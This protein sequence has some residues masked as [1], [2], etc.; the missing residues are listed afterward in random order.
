MQ[1]SE[2]KNEEELELLIENYMD[3]KIVPVDFKDDA[4]HTAYATILQE[5][6]ILN[7]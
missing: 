5:F 6:Q 1:V 4:I 7:G 3:D 2:I